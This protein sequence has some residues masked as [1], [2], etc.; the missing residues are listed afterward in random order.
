MGRK[1]EAESHAT[2]HCFWSR[3]KWHQREA[4][5]VPSDVTILMQAPKIMALSPKGVM[6]SFR[7]RQLGLPWQQLV[8]ELLRLYV[9]P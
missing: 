8:L 4:A 2:S 5:G 9:G 1:R 6:A 3:Q 7:L